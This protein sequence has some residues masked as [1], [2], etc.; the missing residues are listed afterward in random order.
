MGQAFNYFDRDERGY[1]G[2][3]EL[4]VALT[5]ELWPNETAV[6][7]DVFR[8]VDTDKDGQ[9]SDEIRFHEATWNRLAKGV[10]TLSKGVID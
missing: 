1:S 8:D 3:E 5:D 9:I 4:T 10:S 2:V 6:I 7:N